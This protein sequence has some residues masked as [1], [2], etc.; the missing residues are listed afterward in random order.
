[1][2]QLHR[3]YYKVAYLTGLVLVLVTLGIE[4][5][6]YQ[7]HQNL[8]LNDLKNRL[9]EHTI[10]INFRSRAVQ[11]YVNGLK[12]AA[13]NSLIYIKEFNHT[14][15]LYPLIKDSSDKKFFSLD[16]KDLKVNKEAVGNFS[17]L[18]SIESLSKDHKHEINMALFLNTFFEVALKNIRG[19]LRAYYISKNNFQLLYPWVAVNPATLQNLEHNVSFQMAIS[20]SD[21]YHRNFWSP[22]YKDQI[23]GH[24]VITNSSPIYNGKDFLGVISIDFSLVELNRVVNQFASESGSLFLINKEHQVLATKGVDLNSPITSLEEFLSPE[25]IQKI[26]QEIHHPTNWFSLEGP[27]VVYVKDLHTAPWFLV[28][29]DSK[30]KIF[31][32]AFYDALQGIF[33]ISLILIVVVGIGYFLVMRNFISPS[34]KLVKHIEKENKGLKSTPKNLPLRW[35]SLFDIVS[36]IFA[37]NRTLLEDL[38]H[39]VQNRTQQLEQKNQEL[40]QTLTALKKAK[41]QI[42]VQEK[43]SSLGSLTAGIAHEI[44]NPLNFIINFTDLSLEYL[45]ALKEK[46]SN[47]NELFDLIEQ[48][49]TK[50]REHAEKA[51]A[52]VKAMLAHARGGTGEMTTFNFNELLEQAV[53]LAYFGFQGQEHS[54]T[55][56]ITKNF[57]QSIGI[58]Q[59]FSPEL[60][61]V[62]LNI[63]NNACFSMNEKRIALGGDYQPELKVTTQARGERIDIIF[64]DNG[65]GMGAS[66]LRKI[67]NP[68]FTTKGAGKGTGLGLSLSHDI[69]VRQHHG[70]LTADSKVGEYSRLIIELP[71]EM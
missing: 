58:I 68:F 51:D 20:N 25:M 29:V 59:G 21:P 70:R 28:Y 7:R 15:F 43:L 57:D 8:V 52:I 42:I 55:A 33:M 64:Q 37:E 40:E 34:E 53:D 2:N 27:S 30:S 1:M 12:M 47:E 63:V 13:E 32:D 56:K 5:F 49:M 61:R 66:I 19:G 14:S 71:K 45:H 39:R 54:F 60:T 31:L 16:V 17:G 26:N 41:N 4:Y 46:I 23:T 24:S 18:G 62:F 65:R 3:G 44:K 9:D 69:I 35:Q 50:S 11:G 67:F 10:N 22:V 48:N 6:Q 38:E 36:R